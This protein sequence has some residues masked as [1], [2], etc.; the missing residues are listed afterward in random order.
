MNDTNS[1]KTNSVL[2]EELIKTIRNSLQSNGVL[3]TTSHAQQDLSHSI[4]NKLKNFFNQLVPEEINS[5][6]K[7]TT[8][9]VVEQTQNST[10]M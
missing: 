2:P 5:P 8:E 3:P 9:L 6:N 4:L 10:L 1:N 7:M